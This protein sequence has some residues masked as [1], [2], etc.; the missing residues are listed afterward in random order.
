MKISDMGITY[1][2]D[3]KLANIHYDK[4]SDKL[5][6]EYSYYDRISRR[7]QR[8][9]NVFTCALRHEL[10]L[11]CLGIV[12]K[13]AMPDETIQKTDISGDRFIAVVF[14]KEEV[15]GEILSRGK[16]AAVIHMKPFVGPQPGN[17]FLKSFTKM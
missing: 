14:K 5:K 1:C 9:D 8:Y 11:G 17:G 12:G 16:C 7:R 13:V 3:G 15:E 6:I 2:K 4:S 10:T